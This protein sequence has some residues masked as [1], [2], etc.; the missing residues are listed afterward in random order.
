MVIDTSAVV[1]ILFD[2]VDRFSYAAV[3]DAASV[4][5]IS[6]VTRIGL[7]LVVEG[8]KREAGREDLDRFSALTGLKVVSLTPEQVTLATVASR[9]FGKARHLAG[10]DIGDRFPCRLASATGRPLLFKGNESSRTDIKSAVARP[11]VS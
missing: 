7:S 11:G 9:K 8:R 4:R 10:L 5:L 3:I 2:Q 1:A 6:A